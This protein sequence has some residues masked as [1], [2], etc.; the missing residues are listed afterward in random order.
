MPP[1]RP[2][3]HGHSPLLVGTV[4]ATGLIVAGSPLARA[5]NLS[6]SGATS[7]DWFDGTNWSPNS[8]PTAA[9]NVVV[10]QGNPNANPSIGI[11][12]TSN[13]AT[14]NF[15]VIG[16]TAGTTGAVTVNTTNAGLPASWTISGDGSGG[17]IPLVVG[18]SG[19]GFLTI[20]NGGAVTTTGP[21]GT[22]AIGSAGTGTVTV[23]SATAPNLATPSTLTNNGP[24]FAAGSLFVGGST[25]GGSGSGTLIINPDGVVS[26]FSA[27]LLADGTGTHGT[28]VVNGGSWNAGGLSV[29]LSGLGTLTIQNGGTVTSSG[30]S[31][32]GLAGSAGSSVTVT[33]A[34]STW[35]TGS[36]TVGDG[37]TGSLS[38]LAGGT[39]NAVSAIEINIGPS[40]AVANDGVG[41]LIVDNGKLI[42]NGVANFFVG[43]N[44]SPGSTMTVRN[45]GQVV[46]DGGQVG[47][48]SPANLSGSLATGVVT[49]TGAGSLWDAARDS[50]NAVDAA[51]QIS[52]DNPGNVTTLIIQQGGQVISGTG[53][54]GEF[55]QIGSVN[56]VVVDGVG[57]KW[58]NLT[59]LSLG[60]SHA[61]FFF[62][63][64]VGVVN[65]SNGGQVSAPTVIIG[66]LPDGGGDRISVSGTGSS[67]QAPGTLTV[68]LFGMGNLTVSGGAT[69]SS[70]SAVIGF[71]SA[72]PG[73]L[74]Q[75]GVGPLDTENIGANSFGT[76]LVTGAGSTWNTGS[77]IVGDNATTDTSGTFTG[78]G[79]GTATGILTV[80]N[81]GAVN[82]TN[83][84]QVALNSGST[85]TI[86]IGAADGQA[87]AA[88]GTISAPAIVFGAGTG[89]IVFNHTS[90]SYVF[91]VPIQ[92]PGSVI[93]D[94]GT[95]IFTANNSYSGPT[96]INGGTLVVNGSI[97]SSATT[98]NNGGTLGGTG[99][100]GA[101]TV[102]SGGS[103][104]P[105]P[106]GA[107][108]TITVAGNLAFQS[109]AIY[110]V[111][112]NPATASLANV[113]GT[114]SLA[115]SVRGVLAPGSYSKHSYDILHA[116]GGLGGTTFSGVSLNTPNFSASLSYS[117]TDVFLNL[118]AATL[119]AGTPLN[120]NQQNVAAVING[121][122]NNDGTLPPNFGNLFFL[123]GGNLANALSLISGEAAT[124]A[125]QGAFQLMT[126]FLGIMLD[127]FVDGRSGVGGVGGPALGFAPDRPDLPE[128]I[129]LAYSKVM[130]T[131]VYKAPP[132]VYEPRW[133]S[134]GAGYGGYNRTS[135]DPAVVGSHDL[136][137][138]T[139][140]YAAGLDYHF[141]RD[142]VFGFA[143]AGGGTKWDL[144][145]G[146][147]GGK[148][149]AFQAGAYAATRSGPAYFAASL[150]FANYWM[151]TDRFAA[152][153]DHLTAD[154][155]AQSF[156]GRAEAGYRFGWPVVGITPYAAL[157]AQN[158]HTPGY[159]EVDASAGGFGLTYNS[160]TGTDTR[161]E[162]G[163]R[164]DYVTAFSRDAV[165]TWRGR[166]AW[167]HDWVSD[168]NAHLRVPGASRRELHR[169]RRDAGEE[170]RA[171]LGRRGAALCQRR[172]VAGQA[173]RR[174]RRPQ[175]HLCRHRHR[176]LDVVTHAERPVF[177]SRY[178]SFSAFRLACPSLPMIR[179]SCTEMPSGRATS[180]I[181]RVISMSARDGVGSPL[182]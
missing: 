57:S 122:F 128:E 74:N 82:S 78:I 75:T 86:N 26:G 15:A 70:G 149:D 66:V 167:A 55:S 112:V 29:G 38:I 100:V 117:A 39:V 157:Q 111:Q 95:T 132:V 42:A 107:P 158:F 48:F 119:G 53:L 160:R 131:P 47:G 21:I 8:V 34:N 31:V 24:L 104:A 106:L 84:I 67:L 172:L 41:T 45:G 65:I 44:G 62:D 101:V 142:T 63:S 60:Y 97:A 59:S 25:G 36:F 123:T 130:K 2:I 17:G 121:F 68:G 155:K 136:T 171:R 154:F 182:G 50:A 52:L 58:T 116:T 14:S 120:Q 156:A 159:S 148:S 105:G 118:N 137:A 28:V 166:L 177:G 146:L 80:A 23:G 99:T 162:L 56:T 19:T 138:R 174:V 181:A 127:P 175:Q 61:D 180:T 153:G 88:P 173:R 124:G 126:Q 141:T 30:A 90:T 134:W 22:V 168:P 10:N 54:V 98:V 139:A 145:L 176:A 6:W 165:L 94:S 20:T 1:R 92:G 13:A 4:L 113:T 27:S 83:A 5:A 129:A 69:V 11:N 150:A 71:S 72:A 9:D 125:Q 32:A 102:N 164:F 147:G 115:G 85:G 43:V 81:G 151:S 108:G 143:L 140:G 49:V 133:S 87:A 37:A 161:S 93:V 51:S 3:R 114:A 109:G 33:G 64:S 169:Q 178:I 76:V 110:L 103:F 170:L 40:P 77:L 35:N 12:G 179:W 144:A 46:T 79:G 7:A 135:G 96:T 16:D 18:G 152:F 73:S 91:A 89:T 163:S